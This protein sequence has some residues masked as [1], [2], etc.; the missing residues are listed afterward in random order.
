VHAF[1]L[2]HALHIGK[3]FSRSSGISNTVSNLG[4]GILLLHLLILLAFS[5][6]ILLVVELIEKAPLVQVTFLDFLLFVGLLTNKLLLHNP[7][8]MPSM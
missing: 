7:P 5:M 8:Q 6:L 3:P 2:P 4:F 1:K